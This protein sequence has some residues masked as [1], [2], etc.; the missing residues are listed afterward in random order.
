MEP[1][2]KTYQ[3]Q[4][5]QKRVKKI[6]DFYIHLLVYSFINVAIIAV[7]TRDEDLLEGLQ[8]WGNYFTAFF[9][10]IGLFFHWWSV[11]GPDF[12]FGKNWE[13]KKIRQLMEKNK[14]QTWE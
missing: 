13:E 10:G 12:F 14:H 7:N 5:A 11:F 9:W 2:E 3:Y 8:D 6:K 1:T 4:L